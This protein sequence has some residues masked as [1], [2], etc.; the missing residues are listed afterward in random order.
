MK[1]TEHVLSK[2]EREIRE[3]EDA[4]FNNLKTPPKV[5]VGVMDVLQLNEQKT[6]ELAA[7]RR[8]Q[9]KREHR[10]DDDRANA[11]QSAAGGAM[12]ANNNAVLKDTLATQPKVK[13]KRGRPPQ[14]KKPY[15][16][17]WTIRKK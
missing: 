10:K 5:L 15:R 12:T 11:L 6:D 1:K 17:P 13:R 8:I 9:R 16:H 3:E 14:A 7:Q 2:R 4:L